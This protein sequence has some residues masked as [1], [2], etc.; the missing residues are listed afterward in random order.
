MR[1]FLGQQFDVA[2]RPEA[3]SI[4]KNLGQPVGLS[5]VSIIEE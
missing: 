5:G 1:S 2:A 3:A 4:R